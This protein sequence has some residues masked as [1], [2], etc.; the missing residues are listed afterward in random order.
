MTLLP[1][2]LLLIAA[3]LA[4]AWEAPREA[5]LI[6]QNMGGKDLDHY[7]LVNRR[8][9]VLGGLVIVAW[10]AGGFVF[11]QIPHTG[12]CWWTAMLPC[13]AATVWASFTITHR[14]RLN[15]LRKMDWRYTSPGNDYDWQFIVL[16]WHIYWHKSPI[17]PLREGSKEQWKEL[18]NK[19]WTLEG[20]GQYDEA[21]DLRQHAHQAGTLAY[22]FEL[23]VLALSIGGA[24]WILN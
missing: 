16:A 15:T 11:H 9:F 5:K 3:V 19:E 1:F 13:Y 21:L 20:K 23:V 8:M 18:Y 14:Y 12:L 4:W 17:R 22:I 7:H 6:A 2:A 24:V 10:I